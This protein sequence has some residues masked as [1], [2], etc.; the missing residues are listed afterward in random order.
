MSRLVWDDLGNR[1]YETGVSKGVL[2]PQNASGKYPKGV[3]W[4]GLTGVTESPSGAEPTS[5]YADN[6]KYLELRSAEELGLTITAYTYPDEFAEC[7]GSARP[8]A[9]VTIG[10]Q[11]RHA[12]GLSYQT[13]LGNDVSENDYGYKIH[14]IYGCK[15]S[16]SERAYTTVNDSPEVVEFSWEATTTPVAVNLEGLIPTSIL[17]INSTEANAIALK[18]LEEILYGNDDEDACLPLPDE[19]ISILLDNTSPVGKGAFDE[20]KTDFGGFGKTEDFYGEDFKV[21]WEGTKAVVTGN[22]KWADPTEKLSKAGNYYAF[23]L[24]ETYKDVPITID[25]GGTVKTATD[26]DWVCH[27]TEKTQKN[28]LT[29]TCGS[30]LIA[31]FDFSKVVLEAGIGLTV[32]AKDSNDQVY[33]KKVSELQENIVVEKDSIK[34]NL[35]KVTGYTQ[36]FGDGNEKDGNFLALEFNIEEGATAKTEVVGGTHGLV[37]VTA[38]KYCVYRITD[39]EKQS[40]K[41]IATKGEGTRTKTYSLTGLTLES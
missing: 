10:Q 41:V 16:A 31:S 22:L 26:T 25:N 29:V 3:A 20:E 4:N 15:A 30:T 2:Y 7:D 32:T 39:K 23:S 19:V 33:G 1:L 13:I 8:V 27:I 28:G 36:A 12:F 40:I 5:L 9:G 17:T 37:D 14:L 35:K 38:D 11:R 6:I 18:K 24:G 21:E 34:G